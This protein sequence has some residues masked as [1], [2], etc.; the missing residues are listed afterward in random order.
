MKNIR[1][2]LTIIICL[3]VSELDAQYSYTSYKNY[4]FKKFL[5]T[6]TLVPIT[7]I[8]SVDNKIRE[9]LSEHWT[10]TELR[11]VPVDDL[12]DYKETDN[13]SIINLFSYNI[14]NAFGNTSLCLY[15]PTNIDETRLTN[16][17]ASVPIKCGFSYKENFEA[18]CG[19]EQIDYKISIL[20]KQLIE[21]IEFVVNEKYKPTLAHVTGINK[22]VEEFNH[23]VKSIYHVKYKTLLLSDDFFNNKMDPTKFK[24]YY[25][26]DFK[27][28]D[29]KE[30]QEIVNSES[31][32]Y[33]ILTQSNIPNNIITVFD[34]E[35]RETLYIGLNF[36]KSPFTTVSKMSRLNR[37]QVKRLNK[38][39]QKI[40]G[41]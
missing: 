16:V 23:K 41:E 32:E 25:K 35:K 37:K 33:L 24:K 10:Y 6:E 7:G 20:L 1:S 3:L 38:H 29:E 39:I 15:I 8:Q 17:I 4:W 12:D 21:V 13:V 22:Y 30:Y 14:N 5:T 2:F 26:L 34:F 11:Y 9:T 28:V 36:A 31:E 27:I 40:T 18:E 19:F